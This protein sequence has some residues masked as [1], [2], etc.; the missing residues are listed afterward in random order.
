MRTKK[1][2]ISDISNENL[3][4]N[5]NNNL[6]EILKKSLQKSKKNGY[7]LTNKEI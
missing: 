6:E 2:S 1:I 5:N 3:S 4:F 7:F